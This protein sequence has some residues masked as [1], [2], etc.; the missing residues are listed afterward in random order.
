MLPWRPDARSPAA[1]HNGG[2]R[3]RPQSARTPRRARRRRP[4][5]ARPSRGPGSFGSGG[6]WAWRSNRRTAGRAAR[7]SCSTRSTASGCTTNSWWSVACRFAA[8]RAK[9]RSSNPSRSSN[10][11]VK[12]CTGRSSSPAM[13]PTIARRVDAA[14]QE[15]PERHVG[16]QSAADGRLEQPRGPRAQPRRG[17]GPAAAIAV[18]T[19]D[20]RLPIALDDRLAARFEREHVSRRQTVDAVEER[21]RRWHVT[22]GQIGRESPL[23]PAAGNR[24]VGEHRLDLAA[25]HQTPPRQHQ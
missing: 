4:P 16:D 12:V 1:P 8:R 11:I 15:R 5:T 24:G 21:A 17:S 14:T 6:R 10:P 19:G 3:A 18:D 13:I 25:E 23:D 20:R 7:P 22:E 2:P 9:G